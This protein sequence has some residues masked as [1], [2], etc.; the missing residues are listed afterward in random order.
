MTSR[1][2][3]RQQANAGGANTVTKLAMRKTVFII[4]D[5]LKP[6]TSGHNLTVKIV[7]ANTVLNYGVSDGKSGFVGKGARRIR[8][9]NAQLSFCQ[10]MDK[11]SQIL[12][13]MHPL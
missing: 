2:G 4:V 6:G 8:S 10:L 3:K 11:L 9:I 1:S 12:L 13:Q 7:N 5:Q